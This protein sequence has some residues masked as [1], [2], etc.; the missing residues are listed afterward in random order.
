MQHTI[1]LFGNP[2]S[3]KTTL[4]NKLTGS[5]QHVGNWPGVTIEK[6]L[7]KLKPCNS[8]IVDLPGI[9]SLSPYSPEEM[10]SRD[11][12][13]D[14]QPNMILNI[15]DASNIERNLYLTLQLIELNKPMLIALN[16]IDELEAK[17]IK[18]DCDKLELLLGVPVIPI[19]AKKSINTDKLIDKC[20]QILNSQISVSCNIPYDKTTKLTLEQ[21]QDVIVPI[22]S[23]I[24]PIPFACSKIIEND[25]DIITK[26]ELS[27]HQNNTIKAILNTYESLN[28]YNADH[29]TIFADARYKFIENI[30]S[31]SILNRPKYK[32]S[33]SDK[34]DRVFTNKYLGI[35]IFILVMYI[36]FNITFGG[37]GSFLQESLDY[38][39]SNILMPNVETLLLAYNA[40]N[41]LMSLAMDGII[42]GVG[43]IITFVP[44]I[45][46]LFLFL[47]ILED[48]GYISRAAFILD[49]LLKKI[50]LSG[51]SFIPI[52]MGF[53]CTTPAVMAARTIENEADRKL[54][55]ML[56]P[57]MS[58]SARFVIYALFA[59]IFFPNYKDIVILSMYLL[60][61]LVAIILGIILKKTLFKNSI[62]QFILELP[63]YRL[64]NLKSVLLNMWDKC[65]GFLIRAGTIIFAMSVVIWFLQ[66]FNLSFH[67]VDDSSTSILGM[68]GTFIAPIFTPLGFGVWQAVIA[69]LAGFIAKESVVSTMTVIYGATSTAQL[70]TIISSQFNPISAFSFMAFSLLYIPCVSA[71]ISIKREMN[72][73][74]WAVGAATL[75]TG[76]AYIVSL[77]IF[78]LG[79][80]FSR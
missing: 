10:I 78:Q 5:N 39:F 74:K 6:K 61:I 60:G 32:E 27:P 28:P 45:A 8:I 79:S 72:S 49:M 22:K 41:W 16:M 53:G 33:L 76:T 24:I 52:L 57:F 58:C 21:I 23:N 44:Q 70:S 63:P 9:Y 11:F 77:L 62:S 38:L 14:Q 47:S 73:W 50:G 37:L 26:L 71:F 12:I 36:M 46:L 19:S 13:I 18:I 66:N 56:T 67:M 2:N 55:I 1:T 34:L 54:T 17:N 31:K 4:F 69:L 20:N 25:L 51:K 68:I 15:V 64:P 43:G 42:G 65:K 59:E 48:T 30:I 75:Q 3:G 29:E 40:P 7:G 80:I 35:P